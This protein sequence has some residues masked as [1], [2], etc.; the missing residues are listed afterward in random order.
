MCAA[1]IAADLLGVSA[2]LL[3]HGC[4]SLMRRGP[5]AD[6]NSSISGPQPDWVDCLPTM[7]L[8]TPTEPASATRYPELGVPRGDGRPRTSGSY[9]HDLDGLRGVA[10][11]LVAGFHIWFGRVS[12]GVDVFLVLSGFFF[13]GKLL[14]NALDTRT[15]AVAG[16]ELSAAAA[17]LAAGAGRR[18]RHVGGTDDPDPAANPLGD[19]RRPEPG[20]P[21]LLPELGTGRAPTSDYLRAGEAVSPLQH[22]WSMSVQGQFYIAFLALVFGSA[23]LLRRQLGSA[24][25]ELLRGAAGRADGVLLRLR[26]RSPTADQATAYYNSFARAWELLLGALVGALVR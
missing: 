15:V 5:T 14:R 17:A 21:G 24:A 19:V 8:L 10:I 13:G 3:R 16:R 22:M 12:G 6:G 18:A 25:A 26:D 4:T 1:S 23:A 20:Q 11:L 9:R 2:G 7:A